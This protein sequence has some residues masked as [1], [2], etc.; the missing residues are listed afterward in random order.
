[1]DAFFPRG[2]GTFPTIESLGLQKFTFFQLFIPSTSC[3]TRIQFKRKLKQSARSILFLLRL[4]AFSQLQREEGRVI[5]R[6]RF[7][8]GPGIVYFLLCVYVSLVRAATLLD[9]RLDKYGRLLNNATAAPAL[10]K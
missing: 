4:C 6:K 7:L 1:V 8:G 5:H 10:N 3:A 9:Y 2:G